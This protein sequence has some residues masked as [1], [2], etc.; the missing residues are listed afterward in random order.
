MVIVSRR[1]FNKLYY[2]VKQNDEQIVMVNNLVNKNKTNNQTSPPIKNHDI[3]RLNCKSVI[4][5]CL[6][7]NK[8]FVSYIMAITSYIMARTSYIM[9]RTSYIMAIT[10]YIMARTSYIMA[11]TS[12]IMARTSY[13][14][15]RTSYIMAIT[16]YIMARTSIY[17][18]RW[19][20]NQACFVL[21]QHA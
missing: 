9:A 6:T 3:Y 15:A 4:D 2:D 16:S 19:D 17:S 8:R 20:D 21:N 5:W 1:F 14:M 12:Y 11:R 18:M 7:P 10:S 13:I